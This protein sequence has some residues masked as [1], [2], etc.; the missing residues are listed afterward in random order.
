MCIKHIPYIYT[1]ENEYFPTTTVQ[2]RQQVDAVGCP[3]LISFGILQN[4]VGADRF[5]LNALHPLATLAQ[6]PG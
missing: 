2:Q 1:V 4:L 3:T 6:G 5:V